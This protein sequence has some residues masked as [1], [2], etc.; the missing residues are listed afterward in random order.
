MDGLRTAAVLKLLELL[1]G[2]FKV[3]LDRSTGG[4]TRYGS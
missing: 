2:Q 1:N 3:I 4:C